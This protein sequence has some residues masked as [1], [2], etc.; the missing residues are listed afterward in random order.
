MRNINNSK[1]AIDLYVFR[2]LRRKK[3]KINQN[4]SLKK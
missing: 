4:F 2:F 3:R 1:L